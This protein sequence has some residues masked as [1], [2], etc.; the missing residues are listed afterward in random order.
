ME[1]RNENRMPAV[2]IPRALLYY[3]Y[4]TLWEHFFQALGVRTVPSP[5]G[6]RGILENGTKLAPD[7]SCLSLKMFMGHVETLIGRC[8]Q[9]FL[10][11]ARRHHRMGMIARNPDPL[12][13]QRDPGFLFT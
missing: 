8:E 9:I 1:D 5:P 6:S 13:S 2:G 12:I 4:G 3:R 11:K 7:E 10:R